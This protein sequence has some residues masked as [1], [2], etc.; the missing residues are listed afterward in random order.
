IAIESSFPRARFVN[1]YVAGSQTA[2]YEAVQEIGFSHGFGRAEPNRE[3][4]EWMREYNAERGNQV[5]LRFYG[6]DG[7]T[8]M[9]G[10]DSPRQLLNFALDYL[11][12]VDGPAGQDRRR[13]IDLLLGKDTD[14]ENSAAMM[15]PSQSIGLSP[16][17][18]ELRIETENLITELCIRR[19][20]LV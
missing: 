5:N 20:E 18:A 10:T 12:S 4:V 1:D 14:W 15:D 17:A 9:T 16:A 7:P 19:P 8:E 6:L 11:A 3:L 13:R 2:S